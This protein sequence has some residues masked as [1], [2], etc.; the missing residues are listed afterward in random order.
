MKAI[1]NTLG[2]VALSP[3]HFLTGSLDSNDSGD[4]SS[5]AFNALQTDFTAEQYAKLNHLAEAIAQKEDVQIVLQQFVNTDRA[6]HAYMRE[7]KSA[8]EKSALDAVNRFADARNEVIAQYLRKNCHLGKGNFKVMM[9]PEE[10]LKSFDGNDKFVIDML[11][12]Q[13]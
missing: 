9:A 2:K 7:H 8:T 11:P 5:I 10:S 3:I 4:W 6:V 13:P 1:L 12:C